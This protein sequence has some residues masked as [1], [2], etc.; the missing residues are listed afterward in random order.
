MPQNNAATYYYTLLHTNY[1]IIQIVPTINSIAY[2]SIGFDDKKKT[3]SDVWSNESYDNIYFN[4]NT[5]HYGI[6]S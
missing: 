3:Y 4:Y 1:A 5:Y 2:S 6:I